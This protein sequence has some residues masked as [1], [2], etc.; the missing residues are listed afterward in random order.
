[1][2]AADFLCGLKLGADAW[3]QLATEIEG[4]PDNVAPS[5]WGGLVVSVGG[6]RIMCSRCDFPG[7]WTI[8]AVTPEFELE[9]RVA[10]AVL[11]GEVPHRHAVLNVQ[12]AAFLVAQVIQGR[13]EGLREAMADYLHQPYRSK[14]IPGLPE[15]LAIEDREG[16]LGVALSGAGPTV[17]A[18][19]DSHE[20][21]IGLQ[22][23]Q[24]F[25]RHGLSSRV[26]LL[27]ADQQ[28]LILEC[29]ENAQR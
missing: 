6:E 10:R 19:A 18:L 22:I 4:H 11:P 14:L 28:G 24:I 23:Q 25:G 3:L 12:R 5:L 21:D 16:L 8:V 13:R 7:D 2:A 29:L 17:I 26:R 20:S 27:K 15:I 1:V 9:T